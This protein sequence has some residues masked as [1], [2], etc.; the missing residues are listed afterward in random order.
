M[1]KWVGELV[2]LFTKIILGRTESGI[3]LAHSFPFHR[4]LCQFNFGKRTLSVTE[5]TQSLIFRMELCFKDIVRMIPF[6][7][8]DGTIPGAHHLTKQRVLTLYCILARSAKKWNRTGDGA[9]W[10]RWGQDID[11]KHVTPLREMLI[12]VLYFV[13][14]QVDEFMDFAQRHLKPVIHIDNLDNQLAKPAWKHLSQN[15]I[16]P[17]F[18]RSDLPDEAKWKI[19]MLISAGVFNRLDIDKIVDDWKRQL[20]DYLIVA[21]CDYLLFKFKKLPKLERYATPL[22]AD[23]RS[24]FF[25]FV[26]A[27][28]EEFKL[29]G[30]I[31]KIPTPN[32]IPIR[33][34]VL[35]PSRWCVLE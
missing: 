28:L 12:M 10:K 11:T 20:P 23:W 9:A 3:F 15:W 8:D 30:P 29:Q 7:E 32:L 6:I 13:D 22:I 27:T 16:E 26:Q 31:E 2:Q 35:T 14:K 17:A 18:W 4:V 1:W 5:H 25:Q 21:F 34:F 19:E 24:K 33:R